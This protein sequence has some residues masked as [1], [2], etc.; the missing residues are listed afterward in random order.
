MPVNFGKF[1]EWIAELTVM[2]QEAEKDLRKPPCSDEVI[3]MRDGCM[4]QKND[5][6]YC[7]G[8]MKTA[9]WEVCQEV[10]RNEHVA[11]CNTLFPTKRPPTTTTTTKPTTQSSNTGIIIGGLIGGSILLIAILVVIFLMC[12]KKKTVQNVDPESSA[13]TK[14][15][16][17]SKTGTK[18]E[19]TNKNKTKTATTGTSSGI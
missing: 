9:T 16:N 5:A 18:G 4:K 1:N 10:K 2:C 12:R 13:I 3:Q 15:Q 14:S 19:K 7:D 8:V 11:Y 6:I 17:K